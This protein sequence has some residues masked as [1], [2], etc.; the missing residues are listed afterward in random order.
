MFS[1]I[2]SKASEGETEDDIENPKY[3]TKYTRILVSKYEQEME[4]KAKVSES[5]DEEV[6]EGVA[7]RSGKE[8]MT[9]HC[10]YVCLCTSHTI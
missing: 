10:W 4:R 6:F 8:D 2:E 9:T 3:N 5:K 7:K 1:G